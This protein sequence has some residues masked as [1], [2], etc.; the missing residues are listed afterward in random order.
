[1]RKLTWSTAVNAPNFCVSPCASITGGPPLG[2]RGVMTGSTWPRRASSGSILMNAFSSVA[3]PAR[4]RTSSGVP[5][6]IT[7]PAFIAISQAK[8]SASSM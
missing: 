8:R 2:L 6:P 4:L 7:L 3:S 1:M 5:V